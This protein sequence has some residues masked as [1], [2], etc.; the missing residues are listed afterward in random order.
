MHGGDFLESLTGFGKEAMQGKI[1][2]Y[3]TD[4]GEDNRTD[5]GRSVRRTSYV[6]A[7]FICIVLC[8]CT[9]KE[10][11]VLNVNDATQEN[12]YEASEIQ[13]GDVTRI[14]GNGM[15]G[16]Q[17]DG[18]PDLQT[19][20]DETAT[21]GNAQISDVLTGTQMPQG[22]EL[23]QDQTPGVI[24]VHVCGAV[25][26]PGVYELAADSR[27]YEAVE[28]AG[29]FTETADESYVNQAQQLTDGVKLVIPT[30]EQVEAMSAADS[31]K[32][33][34][35]GIVEADTGMQAATGEVGVVYGVNAEDGLSG[36]NTLG[37][38][39]SDGKVNINTASEA[40]LC[41]IPG[42]GA[43]RAAAIVTYRQEMGKFTSVEDIMNVS[44]IKQGTYDKIKDRIK[45]N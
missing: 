10:Q 37:S 12:V 13:E 19:K 41:S 4:R 44:G 43:T 28:E 24:C 32:T 20:A 25:K 22:Q 16:T 11:L 1:R 31:D 36:S 35:I 26:N 15:S 38:T 7:L 6:F 3:L 5:T 33:A 18:E 23:A 27:V 9:R 14:P 34:E 29:G 2:T 40:E 17:G 30:T 39:A 45:V 8:G 42:I 21:E